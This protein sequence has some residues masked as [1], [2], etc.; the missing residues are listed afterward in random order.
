MTGTSQTRYA[1]ADKIS[2]AF[3]SFARTGDPNTSALPAWPKFDLQTRATMFLDN[4]CEVVNDPH[5]GE[6]VA[7][8]KLREEAA[9]AS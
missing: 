3:A 2:A 1:L 5:R 4:E 7:L 9:R 8:A 6:R